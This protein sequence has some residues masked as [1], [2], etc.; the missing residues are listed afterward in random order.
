[1][2]KGTFSPYISVVLNDQFIDIYLTRVQ[3]S[4]SNPDEVRFFSMVVFQ[5][6]KVAID[7]VCSETS[8]GSQTKGCTF[9]LKIQFFLTIRCGYALLINSK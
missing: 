3:T 1:M 7:L 5:V 6:I 2:G 8:R 4:F 9:F